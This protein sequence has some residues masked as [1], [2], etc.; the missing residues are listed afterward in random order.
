MKVALQPLEGRKLQDGIAKLRTLVY[1]RSP[2]SHDIEWHSSVWRWL[3]SHPLGHEMQRW[4][5]VTEEGEVVG[6][7]AAMPQDYRIG[8][9]R[10]VAYTP[11]DYQALPQYGF[12]ALRLMR[13]CGV[14]WTTFAGHRCRR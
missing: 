8:G 1:P 10:I 5:L 4:V 13:Y 2:V 6:H 12:H 9:R 11:A 3:E 7:L 14:L